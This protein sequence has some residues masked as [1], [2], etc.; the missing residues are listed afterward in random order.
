LN[1]PTEM[2][3]IFLAECSEQPQRLAD[4][5][6]AYAADPNLRCELERAKQ[7]IHAGQP[8]VWLGM[9]ASY[10]SSIAGA[11][12]YTLAGHP[13][14][15]V[16]ASEWLHYA[17]ATWAEVGGP[18]LMTTSGE[19]A[20]LVELCWHN[21]QRPRI[22]ICNS[23][24]SACWREADIRLPILAQVEKGN[25]TKSYCNCAAVSIILAAELLGEPWQ[26]EAAQVESAVALSLEHALAER[27]EIESFCRGVETLEIMGRG[28][29]LGGALM[30]ALCVREMTAWRVHAHSSGAF[31]HG[32]F[33]DVDSGHA[34]V[35]LALGRTSDLGRGL[36]RDCIAKGGK[37]VL[38]VD[39]DPVESGAGLLTIK[40]EPV[41]ESWEGLTSVLVPQALTLALIERLG[42]RYVRLNT[43]VQ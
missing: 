26:S 24:E 25:A 28:A 23:P 5:F 18:I 30:G 17:P 4:V 40:L 37:A 1:N 7:N 38:V 13:S 2:K 9:G 32:P 35:I 22:L 33:L 10:C 29:A 31:R 41:P 6:R 16:E 15:P 14:F 34:A 3:E 27:R 20:E 19:S 42:S 36:A 21:A 43:T 8:L 11:T 12:R 39:R